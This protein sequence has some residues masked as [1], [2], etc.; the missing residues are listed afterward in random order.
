MICNA[1]FHNCVLK[2]NQEQS[3]AKNSQ[4]KKK[5]EKKMKRELCVLNYVKGV[6]Q[7]LY[8]DTL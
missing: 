3:V 7:Y 2:K 4:K 6:V 8:G 1:M 5:N